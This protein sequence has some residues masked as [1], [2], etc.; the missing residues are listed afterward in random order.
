MPSRLRYTLYA[1]TIYL[2]LI[3]SFAPSFAESSMGVSLPDKALTLL[4]GQVLL[5]LAVLAYLVSG[6]QEGPRLSL[7]FVA[8][9][10]GHILV[11]GYQLIAGIQ[12]FAQ[13]GP[14]LVFSVMI[15]A[16]LLWFRR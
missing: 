13:V 3:F 10:G 11:F 12:T 16:L 9:F 7:G 14:P 6:S 5:A 2:G 8:L 4:Y 15:T 1:V